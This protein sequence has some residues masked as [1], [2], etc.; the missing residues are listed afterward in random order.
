MK[1]FNFELNQSIILREAR[2]NVSNI[3]SLGD[4][5]IDEINLYISC[6]SEFHWRFVCYLR[7]FSRM[8]EFIGASPFSLS[9]LLLWWLKSTRNFRCLCLADHRRQ[10]R[11]ILY[12]FPE[13]RFF[14]SSTP[15]SLKLSLIESKREMKEGRERKKASGTLNQINIFFIIYISRAASKKYGKRMKKFFWPFSRGIH[16]CLFNLL[17]LAA[18]ASVDFRIVG[19][20]RIIDSHVVRTL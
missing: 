7:S 13:F 12:N 20:E 19:R 16:G 9:R 3:I 5:I 14:F 4:F 17:Y 15:I 2:K 18:R 11:K 8:M 6:M 10:R 1:K